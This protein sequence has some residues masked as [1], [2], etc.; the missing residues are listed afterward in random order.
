MDIKNKM[1][2]ENAQT[3]DFIKQEILKENKV[4]IQQI[5]DKPGKISKNDGVEKGRLLEKTKVANKLFK[6][7]KEGKTL[8]NE[9]IKLKDLFYLE[10]DNEAESEYTNGYM[11]EPLNKADYIKKKAGKV[12]EI[13]IS[14]DSRAISQDTALWEDKQRLANLINSKKT[15]LKIKRFSKFFGFKDF[16]QCK[17]KKKKIFL[18]LTL[19]DN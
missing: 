8:D 19:K 12:N 7:F 18:P 5:L 13:K 15:M 6:K 10:V 11:G 1:A 3:K 17:D 14:Y 2:L 9:I 4:F 16:K